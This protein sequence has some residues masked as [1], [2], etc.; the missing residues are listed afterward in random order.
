MKKVIHLQPLS[1]NYENK[2]EDILYT[3][4]I[5]I[6]VYNQQG[7]YTSHPIYKDVV[8]HSCLKSEIKMI[9]AGI[10]V[11]CEDDLDEIIKMISYIKPKYLDCFDDLTESSK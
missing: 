2:D 11:K 5:L 6:R 8:H 1:Y 3:G 4:N 10:D 7:F 9:E